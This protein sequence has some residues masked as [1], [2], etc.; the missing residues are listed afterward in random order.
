M[1][2][3]MSVSA[4]AR[5]GS[6]LDTFLALYGSSDGGQPGELL[7]PRLD[8]AILHTDVPIKASCACRLAHECCQ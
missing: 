5:E 7:Q 4:E 8:V 1:R 3:N 2:D 6:Q